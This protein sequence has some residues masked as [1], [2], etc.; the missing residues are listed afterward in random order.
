MVKTGADGSVGGLGT[1]DTINSG[2]QN[3][4]LIIKEKRIKV[5]EEPMEGVIEEVVTE[6]AQVEE[7]EDEKARRAILANLNSDSDTHVPKI[8]IIPIAENS[9][10]RPMTETDAYREDVLTR[11]D[12]VCSP[13][14]Y[15]KNISLNKDFQATLEDYERVPVAE[16]GAA[17]LRGMGWKPGQ[18]ASRKRTG[19]VEP[20][21][22]AHRPAL[23]GIGA[24]EL[25]VEDDGSKSKKG[26]K[27]P[28]R[29]YIPVI[30]RERSPSSRHGSGSRRSSRSPASE[31]RRERDP[32]RDRERDSDNHRSRDRDRHSDRKDRHSESD[33]DKEGERDRDR[34]DRHRDHDRDSERKDR[35]RRHRD[36]SRD[37]DH[38]RERERGKDRE[39]GR[40]RGYDREKDR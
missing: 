16:F 22:P 1:R 2:P 29:R 5:E 19:P 20:Y 4:G 40:S 33:R 18:A 21:L 24:K 7:T 15:L 25:V 6:V 9:F 26:L 17:L 32:D 14:T 23:L 13:I 11:P 38:K 28:D 35:D 39:H 10:S 31:K 36:G 3:S 12:E 34:R 8:D 27:K 30:K 37:R